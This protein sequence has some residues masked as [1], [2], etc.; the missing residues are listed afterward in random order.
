[1]EKKNNFF[2]NI[3]M[4]HQPYNNLFRKKVSMD[5]KTIEWKIVGKYGIYTLSDYLL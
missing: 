3:T 4:F 5:A 1:M 2:K